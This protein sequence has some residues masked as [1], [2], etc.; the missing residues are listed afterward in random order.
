[1]KTTLVI[2]AAGIGA[3][4]GGGVK[5][6]STVGPHDELIIDYSIHDAIRAGFQK[7]V[8]IIRKDIYEDFRKRIGF[9]MERKLDE[10]HIE[11]EYV[12]QEMKPCLKGRVKPW[13]TGQAVLACKGVLDGPFAVINADDYYGIDAYQTAQ[14]FLSDPDGNKA[15]RY[16]IL[17]YVLGNTLS[18]HGS[19]TRG[20]C[21]IDTDGKLVGICETKGIV[22]QN[23]FAVA[24]DTATGE[25]HHI[26]MESLVNMNFLL[27]PASFVHTLEEGFQVF[28]Q[29][30]HDPLNEEYLLPV[31][32]D[33]ILKQGI[34]MVQMLP[35][36]DTWFGVTYKEDLSIVRDAFVKLY[37]Q[38][39]Y[40]EELYSDL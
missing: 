8:F 11:W 19:V 4:F 20:V 29:N 9:R 30:L 26:P 12:F 25:I 33:G 22:K 28:L 7:I 36:N 32:L 18:D 38:G 10:L 6:L 23:G 13:G 31:I 27:F 39:V 16:G 34:G 5:Q 1:M 37:E 3:R 2:L 17:T 35:S 15:G 21:Q 14:K 40:A 24:P